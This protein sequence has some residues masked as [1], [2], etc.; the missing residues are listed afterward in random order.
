MPPPV[1]VSVPPPVGVSV[2]PAS[3]LASPALAEPVPV[4]PPPPSY[5]GPMYE[6]AATTLSYHLRFSAIGFDPM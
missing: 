2:P 3:P 5:S 6:V 4:S 1:G